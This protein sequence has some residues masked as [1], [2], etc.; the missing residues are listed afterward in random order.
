MCES[1]FSVCV[2][3]IDAVIDTGQIRKSAFK[4]NGVKRAHIPHYTGISR[5]I[6]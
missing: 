1:E 4:K 6:G 3:S 2:G 5:L